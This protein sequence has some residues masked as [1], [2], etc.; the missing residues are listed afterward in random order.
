MKS[1][2]VRLQSLVNVAGAALLYWL[3]APLLAIGGRHPFD[4][5]A[6]RAAGLVVLLLLALVAWSARQW[7][8]RRH[9][10][11]L[12]TQ[13]QGHEASEALAG[14]FSTAMNLLRAGIEVER[15]GRAWP[16]R[17]RRQVYE[18]PWYVFIGAP[19]A[20]KTTALLH[21]G[22]RF[23]LAERL[24][25]A[26]VAGIGGTRQCDWWFTDRAVFI[27]T[28]GRYTTQDSHHASDAHEWKTFLQL[29]CRYRPVQPINGVIVTVSVPDLI[30]GGA[31]L[32]QQADAV[33]QRLLELRAELGLSFP[34]YLLVTKV[35]LLAG[36][37]EYFG[38]FDASQREKLWGTTFD[39]AASQDALP[40]DLAARLAEL[41]RGLGDASVQRLQDESQP[42]RRALIYQFPAQLEAV[43]PA[44][45]SFARRAFRRTAETPRQAL[46]GV[47]LTS[48]TQE[49]NP[50]DRVL[51]QLSRHYGITM[52][53]ARP[54]PDG[55]SGKAYF[56]STLLQRLVIAE[57]PLAGTNLRRRQRRRWITAGAGSV[58]AVLALLACAG[59]WFSYRSN[60]DYVASVGQRVQQVVREVDPAK[61]R[62][63]DQLLP[64]YAMLSD[65]AASGQ[66]DPTRP[67]F[68][69][70]FGLFQGARLARS[71]D[72]TY[73][74]VLDQTLAPL[75]A[76]RLALALQQ[77]AD[78]VARYDAL[79][80]SLMLL[81]PAHLQ[82]DEV[83]RWAAQAFASSS[84]TGAPG[85]APGAGEQQEWLRHLDALLERNA[86]VGAMRLDEASVRAART[87]LAALP[88]EQRVY[89][90]LLARAR[91]RLAGDRSLAE[92]VSPGAVVAFAPNDSASGVP[93]IAAVNTRQAWREL[94]EPSLDATIAELA[95]EA[96]WVMDE[97]SAA[98]QRL[99]RERA[100]RNE[101]AK[102]VATQ[103]A[104]AT[105]A[106]WDRLLSA[107]TLTAPADAESLNRLAAMLGAPASPLHELLARI[108]LEFPPPAPAGAA[109]SSAQQAFDA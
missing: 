24:G 88:I 77:D 47:Y 17:R 91:A 59:W 109:A 108:A 9:N 61:S 76:Q 25:A 75:L 107:L 62:N 11:R 38:D 33:E 53:A 37:V 39:Y 23:P 96:G 85:Q 5:A 46:R 80:I 44:L 14:R 67:P 6:A 41:P 87:A 16:W 104:Q 19:G 106:Q 102:Q 82:R 3:A 83:R 20:G 105:I 89:D 92:L 27:D 98:M 15:S 48:G 56:L 99:A 36:F 74:R 35:D 103:Y 64:L 100:A 42:Q 40:S 81:T 50:I 22:L 72:Q 2:A 86:V 55:G 29:L 78:P 31:E 68:G 63:I 18:L 28:A 84:S 95:S 43:L 65:L 45:E 13:L 90:R 70:G 97:R 73:H 69:L 7:L 1:G 58:L 32:E 71:A 79:R 101:L 54:R 49:G 60:L 66:I 26:P 10:A 51:G 52:R 93:R 21:S 94:I 4:S 34:V 30:H 12:L 8:R 57:A